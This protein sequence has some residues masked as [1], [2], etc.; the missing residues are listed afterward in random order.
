MTIQG[1]VDG[2]AGTN[3]LELAS[4]ATHGTLTGIGADF[5]N[6]TQGTVDSGAYWVLAGSNTID[7][8]TTLTN[9][10]RLVD[11]GTF[12]NAGTLQTGIAN[13]LSTATAVTVAATG[14]ATGRGTGGGAT[15][16]TGLTGTE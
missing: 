13:A 2:G 10:G 16:Y 5:V 1:K 6:F 11:R 4:A 12:I 15:T 14:T 7:S 3:T 8:T 9:S